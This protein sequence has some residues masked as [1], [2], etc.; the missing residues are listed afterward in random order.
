M[1]KKPPKYFKQKIICC[2]KSLKWENCGHRVG[3]G[4][5]DCAGAGGWWKECE[6]CGKQP[7]L[8]EELL[9][10]KNS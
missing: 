7:Y 4:C 10:D 8:Q 6:T 3:E 5:P 9:F 1:S 2:G